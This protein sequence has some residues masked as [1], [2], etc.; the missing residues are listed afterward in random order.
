VGKNEN[1]ENV[2]GVGP[3]IAIGFFIK[4]K[5]SRKI[6]ENLDSLNCRVYYSGM[7]ETKDNKLK[8]LEKLKEGNIK[9]VQWERLFPVEDF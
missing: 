9:A 4:I 1:D 3:G 6:K 2:F 8:Q 7:K 5:R